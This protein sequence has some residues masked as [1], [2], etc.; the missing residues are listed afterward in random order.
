MGRPAMRSF[1]QRAVACPP[2]P[3]APQPVPPTDDPRFT[4]VTGDVNDISAKEKARPP[5]K[6]KV[7]EAQ[8]AAAGPPNETN[9]LAGAA[10][11]DKMG[12][13]K[14]GTFDKAAFIAAVAKA[15]DAAAPKNPDEADKFKDSGKS[16]EVKQQVSGLVT[17]GKDDSAQDIKSATTAPPDTSGEKPKP[18]TPMT[19]EQPG[20]P[21]PAVAADQAMPAPRGPD[22]TDLGAGPCAVNSQ[23]ADAKVTDDQLK[24]GNEPQFDKALDSKQKAE[25]QAVQ[26]P[27]EVKGAEAGQLAQAQAGAAGTVAAGLASMHA[28]RA[29]AVAGLAAHK[30]GAKS[31]DEAKRAE[32]SKHIEE[33][34]TR[35]KTQVTGLLDSLDQDVNNAFDQGEKSARDAFDANVGKEIADWKDKRYSGITGAAQWLADKFAGLPPEVDQIYARNRATYLANMQ[36]V[37]SDVADVVGDKLTKAKQLIAGGRNEI[38]AYVA[39]Q[40]T[41]LRQFA[42]EAADKMSDQFDSLDSDVNSKQESVVSD[43]AQK[44]V[45]ARQSVDDAITKMQEENKGLV[46]EAEEA[47]EGVIDVILKMKDMLTQ[48][49]SRAANAIERI[50][51]DPIGFLDK[52]V[53]AVKA[54][55]SKFVANIGEHLKK[56]LLDWLFGALANAGIQLPE[57]FDLKGILNLVLS[58]L[59]LTWANIRSR[60]VA[61]VGEAVVAKMEQAVEVFQIIATEGLGGLWKWILEKLGDFKEMVMG[62]IRDFI[63]EKV[64][65]AG[66]EWLIGILNPAAAFIKACEAI[67]NIVTFLVE[68]GQAIAEFVNSVLDSVESILNGGVGAVA[69]LIE[70][71]LA[72][73]I[74]L[75]INLL[76]DLLGLGGISEKIKE[77]IGKIQ[78]P[79]NKGI[80]AII[81]GALKIGKKLFSALLGNGSKQETEDDAKSLA[82]KQKAGDMLSAA[83]A[84]PFTSKDML[85][86]TIGSIAATLKPEGLQSLIAKPGSEPGQYEI[87]AT[88]SP[89][90]KEGTATVVG[91]QPPP[92]LPVKVGDE[93]IIMMD[94]WTHARVDSIELVSKTWVVMCRAVRGELGKGRGIRADLFKEQYAPESPLVQ[95]Y[96]PKAY[97]SGTY[98]DLPEE[99]GVGP[100]KEFTAKQKAVIIAENMRR[101]EGRLVSK[102]GQVL[103]PATVRLAGV[104]VDP[105]EVNIDH[106]WPRA[107]GGWNTYANAEVLSF[108]ENLIKSTKV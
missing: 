16:A 54:G 60:L 28:G 29:T 40:P 103:V 6:T 1:L 83:T 10:Q 97:G 61:Q 43:L 3:V 48:V 55:L 76:A 90:S 105:N 30:D 19:P 38:K 64:I 21:P 41:A 62:E 89:P 98:S 49:L 44:Y 75:L 72:K 81:A 45:A 107:R 79:V 12:A 2:A 46:E 82:V 37:I 11:V 24:K 27:A 74:P 77:I 66:I 92:D 84:K 33:V 31:A 100:Y 32:I 85:D 56:G 86:S 53:T 69:D 67:Y 35:T 91:E 71:T 39:S 9:A 17:K 104:A 25:Q 26:A 42:S 108:S 50:I 7:A 4:K 78:A 23:L 52:L 101:N 70:G 95:P 8:G 93:V 58:I 96:L 18:V 20:P 106:N 13:A 22:Q 57:T 65:K 73:T 47:V 87:E 5:V 99:E 34:F 15:I 14:P 63:A 102:S 36:K 94:E 80:D 68:K 59:G 88:A 51:A